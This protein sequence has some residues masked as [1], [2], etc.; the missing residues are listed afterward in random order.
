MKHFNLDEAAPAPLSFGQWLLLQAG[1]ED[2]T[3]ELARCAQR[4]PKFPKNGTVEDVTAR[5]NAL[6][7]DPDM[8]IAVEDAELDW[9]AM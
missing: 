3:G 4:D 9:A 2:Q 6:D 7:A 1:R 5:L 8:F